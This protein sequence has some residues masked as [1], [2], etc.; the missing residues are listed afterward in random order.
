MQADQEEAPFSQA[1][2]DNC[3][4]TTDRGGVDGGT[5]AEGMKKR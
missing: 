4:L 1:G 3:R 2:E 5:L